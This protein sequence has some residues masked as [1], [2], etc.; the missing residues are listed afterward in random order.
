MTKINIYMYKNKK[1]N[2]DNGKM[3]LYGYRVC[4]VDWDFVF[5]WTPVAQMARHR[6]SGFQFRSNIAGSSLFIFHKSEEWVIN[7]IIKKFNTFNHQ[8]Q[9][10]KGWVSIFNFVI[11]IFSIFAEFH[12]KSKSKFK[13]VAF[14]LCGVSRI[15]NL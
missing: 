14:Y 12:T 13:I 5:L 1:F 4:Y 15:L 2:H 11:S 6:K 9:R 3:G 8:G 7:F 10:E